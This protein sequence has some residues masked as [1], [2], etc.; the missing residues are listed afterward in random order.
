MKQIKRFAHSKKTVEIQARV[1][2][3]LRIGGRFA[4]GRQVS[5]FGL[6]SNGIFLKINI[7]LGIYRL[8]CLSDRIILST[9]SM[10]FFVNLDDNDRFGDCWFT[11]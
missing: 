1:R 7:T 2:Q 8:N 3:H 10:S 6:I 4:L 11:N 5:V 9:I